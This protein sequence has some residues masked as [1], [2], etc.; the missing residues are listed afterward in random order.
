[1]ELKQFMQCNIGIQNSTTVYI[2]KIVRCNKN[3]II[4]ENNHHISTLVYKHRQLAI[5]LETDYV[6]ISQGK[7]WLRWRLQL[8]RRAE[9]YFKI[10]FLIEYGFPY[11]YLVW[12]FVSLGISNLNNADITCFDIV[13]HYRT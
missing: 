7:Y 4:H 6:V 12:F 11:W 8:Y 9:K 3:K 2:C 1:M 13:T 5:I 10:H